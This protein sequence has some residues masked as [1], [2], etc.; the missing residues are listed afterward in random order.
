[1]GSDG[2]TYF[3]TSWCFC[4]LI[5]WLFGCRYFPR[6]RV[7]YQAIDKLATVESN[8][9]NDKVNQKYELLVSLW[10]GAAMVCASVM[11]P[12]NSVINANVIRFFASG[13]EQNR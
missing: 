7:K 10:I 11:K 4:D 2:A 5:G 9:I 8:T 13:L 6:E 12:G 3:V 1:M